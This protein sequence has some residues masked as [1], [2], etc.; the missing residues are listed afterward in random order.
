MTNTLQLAFPTNEKKS[1]LIVESGH[2]YTNEQPNFEEKPQDLDIVAYISLLPSWGFAPDKIVYEA[3]LVNN[4]KEIVDH[5]Q[6]HGDAGPHHNGRII[7]NKGKILL[8]D[9]GNGK[10]MCALLD[11]CLYMQKLEH[12][13]GCVTILDQQYAAQQKGTFTIL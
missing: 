12:A 13:D 1:K 9:P 10:Y 4:A 7:L 11:A 6:K 8:Y 2:I 3:D 5:L